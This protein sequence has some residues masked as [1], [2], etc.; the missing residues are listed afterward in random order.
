M[1]MHKRDVHTEEPA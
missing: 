1:N